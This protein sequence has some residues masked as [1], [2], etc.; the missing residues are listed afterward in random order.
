MV[1]D[2]SFNLIRKAKTLL[3]LTKNNIMPLVQNN[4]KNIQHAIHWLQVTHRN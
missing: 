1:K 2:N 3:R 4:N